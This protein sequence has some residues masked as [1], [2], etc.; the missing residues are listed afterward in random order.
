LEFNIPFQHKYGYIRD[1]SITST[2]W[3]LISTSREIPYRPTVAATTIYSAPNPAL[4]LFPLRADCRR[5][6]L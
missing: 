1:D 4:P 2:K 3:S 6:A 5:G